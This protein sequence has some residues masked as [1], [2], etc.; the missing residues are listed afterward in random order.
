MGAIA[1]HHAAAKQAT[2]AAATAM[3]HVVALLVQIS[4]YALDRLPMLL[5]L[6]AAVWLWRQVLDDPTVLRLVGLGLF[7]ALV[8]APALWLTAYKRGGG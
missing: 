6:G 8:I 1:E 7:G 5:T 3:Q 2:A 4:A